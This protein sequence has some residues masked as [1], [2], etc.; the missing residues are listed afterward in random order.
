MKKPF[1]TGGGRPGTMATNSTHV[2]TKHSN[3]MSLSTG[4]K[5]AAENIPSNSKSSVTTHRG[6][7]VASKPVPAA[8][9]ETKA[10]AASTSSNA[11]RNLSRKPTTTNR[12]TTREEGVNTRL[13]EKRVTTKPPPTTTTTT[14]ASKRIAQREKQPPAKKPAAKIEPGKKD[15]KSVRVTRGSSTKAKDTTSKAK[16]TKETSSGPSSSKKRVKI[17]TPVKTQLSYSESSSD[18]N[19]TSPHPTSS[20]SPQ[21]PPPPPSS[22]PPVPHNP[23]AIPDCAWVPNNHVFTRYTC[24]PFK[25]VDDILGPCTFSPFKFTAGNPTGCGLDKSTDG[26]KSRRKN[27]PFKFSF[28][29]TVDVTPLTLQTEAA[30]LSEAT[31]DSVSVD[32]LDCSQTPVAPPVAMETD[33]VGTTTELATSNVCQTPM[34]PPACHNAIDTDPVATTAEPAT[35]DI[36]ASKEEQHV[37]RDVPPDGSEAETGCVEESNPSTDSDKGQ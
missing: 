14:R 13:R 30:V 18:S 11:P 29:K 3:S 31:L 26:G 15:V 6:K 4:R 5:T 8:T 32:S 36:E 16:G 1:V 28:R 23:G 33:P 22:P 21:S 20:T 25:S 34:P 9:K 24:T 2:Q 27:T 35:S 7:D 10:A 19:D 17:Q 12:V 37:P